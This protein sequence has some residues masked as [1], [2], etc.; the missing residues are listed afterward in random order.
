MGRELSRILPDLDDYL[1]IRDDERRR[2]G[3]E[4]HDS[5][6]QL[7]VSLKLSIAHLHQIDESRSQAKLIDEIQQTIQSIH[8]EIRTLAFLD[9]PAE[10]HDGDLCS[11]IRGLARGLES[12]SGIRISIQIDDDLSSCDSA[13][14]MA[15]LRITQEALA[16]IHRHA[17]ATRVKIAIRQDGSSLS[18]TVDDNGQGLEPRALLSQSEGIGLQG[19][20]HRVESLGGTFKIINLNHGTCISAVFPLT[21]EQ[22]CQRGTGSRPYLMR[23]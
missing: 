20:R 18:L 19:M 22:R 17:K 2:M 4:L 1:K 15:V 5:A 21:S 8:S 23:V 12:R 10:L 11:T 14:S 6:G 7:L 16:N 9:Y 3:R 13:V